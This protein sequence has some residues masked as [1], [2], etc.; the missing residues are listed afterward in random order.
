MAQTVVTVTKKGQATIPKRLREKHHIGRKALVVDTKRG[1]LLEPIPD[2]LAEMGSLKKFFKGKT[3]KE[4]MREL[5]K[6]E[7]E[8]ESRLLKGRSTK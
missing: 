8:R 1:V 4:I 6:E 2:P 7:A 5:R 3:S